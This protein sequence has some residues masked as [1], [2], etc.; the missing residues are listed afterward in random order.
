MEQVLRAIEAL[1]DDL[2]DATG[3]WDRECSD[4]DSEDV[5]KVTSGVRGWRRPAYR[6]AR[7]EQTRWLKAT[8]GDA[9]TREPF[10]KT[11]D[12]Q[13]KHSRFHQFTHVPNTYN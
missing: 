4:S 11:R 7:R 10:F 12:H 1:S 13:T 6:K 8:A 2:V 3:E 9:G 5:L